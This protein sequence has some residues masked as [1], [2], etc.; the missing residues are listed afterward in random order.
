[1][2][3]RYL[4]INTEDEFEASG[5]QTRAPNKGCTGRMLDAKQIFDLYE[6]RRALEAS[7]V[8]IVR[9]LRPRDAGRAAALVEESISRRLAQI[10]EVIR[11]GFAE[12]YMRDQVGAPT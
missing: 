6:L 5:H 11:M 3:A 4:T 2:P 1:M 10:V 7:I 8:R 12:F 9:A